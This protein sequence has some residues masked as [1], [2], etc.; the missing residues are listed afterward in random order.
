MND[1]MVECPQGHPNPSDWK[2]CGECGSSIDEVDTWVVDR[3]PRKKWVVVAAGFVAVVAILVSAIVLVVRDHNGD[4]TMRTSADDAEVLD[5]WSGAREPFAALQASLEDSERALI[6]LDRSAMQKACQR[7][8]DTAAV[9]L[10]AHLPAPT[11]QLTSEVT[12]ATA[13]AHEASHMCMAVLAGSRNSYDAEFPVDV[14]QADKH[15]AAAEQLISQAIT[16]LP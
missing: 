16:N 14:R 13:D 6:D 7:M 5:W 15:L 1:S 9:E 8:H 4:A 12:A 3:W 10:P 11:R 2:L